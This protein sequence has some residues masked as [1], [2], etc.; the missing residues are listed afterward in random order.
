MVLLESEAP[1]PRSLSQRFSSN[2]DGGQDSLQWGELTG[3]EILN[4]NNPT[5][6]PTVA[7][8]NILTQGDESSP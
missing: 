1:V 4:G 6:G 7:L 3:S 8:G 5:R 2:K